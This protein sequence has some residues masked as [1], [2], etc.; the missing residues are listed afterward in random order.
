M[1]ARACAAASTGTL[2]SSS[3]AKNFL[4]IML[5]ITF[6]ILAIFYPPLK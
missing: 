2:P 3:P 1:I 4:Q 6:N 5:R